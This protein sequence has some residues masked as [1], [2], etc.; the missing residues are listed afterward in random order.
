MAMDFAKTMAR[1]PDE[2]LFRIAHPDIGEEYAG[3]AI[4]AAQAEIGKRGISAEEGRQIRYDLFQEREAQLP[5]GEEPLGKAGRIAS[6]VFAICIGPMLLVILMLFFL[7]YREKAFNA[8]AWM[9][10]GLAGY[11]G[12]GIALFLLAWLFS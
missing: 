10:I 5:R 2:A 12:F 7:G 8:A 9:A 4:A 6:M 11:S 1:L 3:E